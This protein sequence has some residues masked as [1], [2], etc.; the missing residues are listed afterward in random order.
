MVA[1]G[2]MVVR[3]RE[4]AWVLVTVPPLFPPAKA[5]PPDPVEQLPAFQRLRA[6]AVPCQHWRC[7]REPGQQRDGH[8][9]ADR[10]RDLEADADRHAVHEAVRGEHERVMV[11]DVT[12]N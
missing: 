6:V 3:S 4:E 12:E 8:G 2:R 1:A 9:Q 10:V 5:I 7:D 11:A